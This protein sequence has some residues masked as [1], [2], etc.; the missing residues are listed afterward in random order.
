V[1]AT[2]VK[3]GGGIVEARCQGRVANREGVVLMKRIEAVV[4]RD[5]LSEVKRAIAAVPHRGLTACDMTEQDSDSGTVLLCR[6]TR[7]V[8]DMAPRVSITV[9]VDEVDASAAV[10][11]IVGAARTGRDGDG[12]VVVVPVD[13]VVHIS[14]PAAVA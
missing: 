9:L 7:R 11:A 4:R 6:G 1:P 10:D 12:T 5:K 3:H 13:E 2:G 8:D 14:S